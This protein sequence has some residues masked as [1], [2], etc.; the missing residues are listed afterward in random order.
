MSLRRT[1]LFG[2]TFSPPHLG[3]VAALEAAW[4]TGWFDRLLVAVAGDP[5]HKDA[6]KLASADRRLAMAHAA[7]DPIAG[8]EVTDREISRGGPTYTVDTVTELVHAG[9][10]V[11][12]IL[13]VDAANGIDDWHRAADLVGLVTL[14]IVPRAGCQATVGSRWR[15]VEIPMDPVNLSSTEIRV[16]HWTDEDLAARVPAAV[17][18]I[19]L[20][21]QG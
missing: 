15:F 19:L 20:A 3:H 7:F 6:N 17:L 2:G 10:H 9:D 21:G 4:E 1:G 13:G 5:Y 11:T 8:V 12:L 14:A 16:G 18:P